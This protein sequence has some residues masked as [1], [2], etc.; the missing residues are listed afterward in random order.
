MFTVGYYLDPPANMLQVVFFLFLVTLLLPAKYIAK[1]SYAV[2][3][4]IFWHVVPIISAIPP[5]DRER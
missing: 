3:G 1:L 2:G 5:P 4:M